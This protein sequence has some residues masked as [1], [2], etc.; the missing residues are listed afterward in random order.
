MAVARTARASRAAVRTSCAPDRAVSGYPWLAGRS[1]N[2]ITISALPGP[3]PLAAGLTPSQ[4]LHSRGAVLNYGPAGWCR[5]C[6]PGG[7][8]S[9]FGRSARPGTD[10]ATAYP[11]RG[12]A[13]DRGIDQQLARYPNVDNVLAG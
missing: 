8:G 10:A 4:R 11:R 6:G 2:G 7:A 3:C 9:G 5:L 12:S 13:G 1:R